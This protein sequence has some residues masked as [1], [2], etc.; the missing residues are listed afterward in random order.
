M[1]SSGA[2]GK[3]RIAQ[4]DG[5]LCYESPIPSLA[6]FAAP[7]LSALAKLL[8]EGAGQSGEISLRRKKRKVENK[9]DGVLF[10]DWFEFVILLSPG[11]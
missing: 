2:G 10:F 8:L 11:V 4:H 6:F 3:T 9:K 7:S 1:L 5:M